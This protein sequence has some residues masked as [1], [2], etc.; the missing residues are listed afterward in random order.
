MFTK[1][2]KK[3][4]NQAKKILKD[5]IS[6]QPVLENPANVRDFLQLQFADL[7]HEVF[8]VMF[9]TNRHQLII[10]KE[11]FR[12]TIDGASVYPREVVKEAL[13][14]NAAAVIFSHNHPSGDNT[15]STAD[16]RITER[17]KDALTLI[18]VRVLDH[19]VVSIKGTVSFAELGYL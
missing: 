13:K 14:R 11:M 15:P 2:E 6:Q 4:I 5:H 9:L 12:G 1:E 17:L 16:R 19:V 3:I 10:M 18:D 8:A 7:E